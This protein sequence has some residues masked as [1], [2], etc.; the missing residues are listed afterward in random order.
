MKRTCGIFTNIAPLYSKPLWYELAASKNVNYT[1]YSSR[2]GFSGIKTIDIN[3]SKNINANGRLN[4]FFLKSIFIRNA[5]VFQF[6]LIAKCFKTNFDCYILLG[7]MY[8]FSNWIAALICK[9]RRKPLLFWGHGLYGNENIIKK[10]FRLLYYKIADF[11]L[12]YGNRSRNILIESGFN[13]DKIYTIYNSLDYHLHCKFYQGRNSDDLERLKKTLFTGN[14]TLPIVIFIGRLTKDKK[15]S[16]LLEAIRLCKIRGNSYNC[17]IVGGGAEIDNLRTLSDS[18]GISDSVLFFGP[19]YDEAINSQLIMLAECCVS[20]GNVG[21]TAIH[22]MTLGTP[23]ITHG[24]M[25]NQGPEAEAV[26]EGV[27]GAFFEENNVDSL[28]RVIDEMI[29]TKG[30]RKMEAN[31]VKQ[32]RDYWNPGK[33]KE[34]FD[35]AVLNSIEAR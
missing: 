14:Y 23:V 15:N 29:L 13:P 17:L 2:S 31:C 34:I 4:W 25:C 10:T 16:L 26:L 20:P 32:I 19:S 9:A 22:S 21:L 27:T 6:G 1:F 5:L 3:E 30:K 18:K 28:S 11:H 35:R 33:Q 7:E 12:V 8:S 24:N